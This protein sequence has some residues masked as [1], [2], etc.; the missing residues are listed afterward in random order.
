VEI[1]E[2]ALALAP[3]DPTILSGYALARARFS[4]FAGEAMDKA[5]AAAKRAVEVAPNL[6]EGRLALATALFQA[7][8]TAGAV[9]ELKLALAK[10]PGLAEAHALMGRILCEAAHT[11][12]GVRHL[13][14]A[15]TLD[16]GMD[17]ARRDLNRTFE[18]LGLHEKAERVLEGLTATLEDSGRTVHL[19]RSLLWHRDKVRAQ[20]VLSGMKETTGRFALTHRIL[21]LVT[22]EDGETFLKDFDT[23]EAMLRAKG[24]GRR[25]IFFA[26]VTAE[27]GAFLRDEAM[28]LDYLSA[29]VDAGLIDFL[30]MERC[31]LLNQVRR[32]MSFIAMRAR[33]E[34]RSRAIGEAYR[35]A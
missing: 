33:I 30:W 24:T 5:M 20:E 18:L 16:P 17:L 23:R 13:E 3:N 31:P 35:S 32:T 8:D 21:T 11:D 9:R 12:D 28:T 2:Q 26:Q 15:L 27:I 19:A 25:S 34:E 22:T 10:G 14:V 1:F 29:A 7:N 6:P 4:F